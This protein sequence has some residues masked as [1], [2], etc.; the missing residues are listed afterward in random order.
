M[1]GL[2]IATMVAAGEPAEAALGSK[3]TVDAR[4][5]MQ[6]RAACVANEWPRD[7][8]ALLQRDFREKD[9]AKGI[10]RLVNRPVLCSAK[11]VPHGTLA[12]GTLLWSGAFAEGLIKR[13]NIL[14]E[15][16][17]R[18]AYR[19]DRPTIEAR[20]AGELM[21]FCVVRADPAG[22]AALLRTTPATVDEHGAIKALGPTLG[23]CV[24]AN[25]QSRFTRESLRALIALG[26]LRLA[27]HNEKAAE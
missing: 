2:L 8:R 27:Q 10:A 23:N 7:V 1:I 5:G 9:Y 22:T 25:S 12:A 6:N 11:A 17:A 15:L 21:A 19:A 3:S 18:T 16:A 20:N 24:P 4:Q 14:E 26:A 13:D